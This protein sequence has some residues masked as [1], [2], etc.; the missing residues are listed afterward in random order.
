MTGRHIAYVVLGLSGF[1]IVVSLVIPTDFYPG[2]V[3]ALGTGVVLLASALIWLQLSYWREGEKKHS[4][5]QEIVIRPTVDRSA[6][7]G[8]RN[9]HLRRVWEMLEESRALMALKEEEENESELREEKKRL[10]LPE[11]EEILLMA[12]P[13][14]LAFWPF[15]I[16]SA[17]SLLVSASTANPSVSFSWLALGLGGLLVCSRLKHRTRYYLTNYRVLVSKRRFLRG[18]VRWF[19]LPYSEI[20][21]CS[22]ERELGRDL[23]RLQGTVVN[24]EIRGLASASLLTARDIIR[25]NLALTAQS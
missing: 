8:L 10:D 1:S 17:S 7:S 2:N 22:W 11:E 18:S 16:L 3:V 20:R 12:S 5:K 13:S 21:L 15:A 4:V 24:V 25:E 19:S 9:P 6:P 14:W 23:L